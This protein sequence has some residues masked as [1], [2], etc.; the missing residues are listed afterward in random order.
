[1]NTKA[2]CQASH[3]APSIIS[4]QTT[5]VKAKADFTLSISFNP[6]FK[7]KNPK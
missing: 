3:P 5:P 6:K 7:I 4:M 1:M 2:W